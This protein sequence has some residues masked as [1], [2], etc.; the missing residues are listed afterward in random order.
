VRRRLAALQL[1][2]TAALLVAGA[3]GSS[4]SAATR[5]ESAVAKP[6]KPAPPRGIHKIKH[7][8]VI[9]Q[10]NR[11]FDSYFGTYPGAD[12]I[13]ANACVPDP[14]N[15]GCIRPYHDPNDLNRG[16]PHGA[17]NAVADVDA[18]RMDGFV[19]Q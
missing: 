15:G 9:M 4:G 18:G 17:S 19:A 10:E 1:L 16:A 12:G 8:I 11:S 3:L 7:V 5:G 13:P 14:A 6:R 2:L